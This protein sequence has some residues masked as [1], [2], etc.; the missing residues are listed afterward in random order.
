MQST[1][2]QDA[3]VLELLVQQLHD[4]PWSLSLDERRRVAGFQGSAQKDW[5]ATL[6]ALVEP[7]TPARDFP[8]FLLE[9]PAFASLRRAIAGKALRVQL[10]TATADEL[11]RFVDL[12]RN[13]MHE[14]APPLISE[15]SAQ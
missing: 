6:P 8:A 4:D 14:L 2:A 3:R 10:D 11:Q 1:P 9:T 12:F 15:A 13:Y 5:I 7:P